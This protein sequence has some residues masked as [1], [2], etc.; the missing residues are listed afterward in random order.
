[1]SIIDGIKARLVEDWKQAT[2]W[3]SVR[4]TAIG[5]ILYPLLISVQA[6]PPEV[7]ALFP[8]RYRAIAAGLFQLAVIAARV[9]GQKTPNG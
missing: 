7:Q 1:M 2:R 9:W 8:L 5:A 4:M 3:W 6:M